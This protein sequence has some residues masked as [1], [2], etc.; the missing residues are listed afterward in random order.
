MNTMR[1]CHDKYKS[2]LSQYGLPKK[3][4]SHCPH[5]NSSE[6]IENCACDCYE[7]SIFFAGMA[8]QLPR[9]GEES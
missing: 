5:E 9:I 7:R 2:F 8:A 6:L 1:D 3:H 4:L